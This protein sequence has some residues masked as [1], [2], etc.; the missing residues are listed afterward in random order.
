M[1]QYLEH[2][3]RGQEKNVGLGSFEEEVISTVKSFLCVSHRQSTCFAA[4]IQCCAKCCCAG[5]ME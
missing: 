1:Q 2:A 5:L 4:G 3:D